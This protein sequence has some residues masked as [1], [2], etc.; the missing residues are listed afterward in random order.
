VHRRGPHRDSG[1]MQCHVLAWYPASRVSC[2]ARGR[3]PGI[4]EYHRVAQPPWHGDH[5]FLVCLPASVPQRLQR[6]QRLR[7][8]E[9]Y[10][11]VMS[12]ASLALQ[13]SLTCSGG[14]GA[15]RAVSASATCRSRPSPARGVLIRESLQRSHAADKDGTENRGKRVAGDHQSMHCRGSDE[16]MIGAGFRDSASPNIP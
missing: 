3:R 12:C 16:A 14:K 4:A 5:G 9:L 7:Q 10:G 11:V 8:S 6:L 13:R 2:H 1:G 15:G